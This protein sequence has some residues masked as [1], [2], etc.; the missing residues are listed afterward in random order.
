MTRLI[1]YKQVLDG[2][3]FRRGISG[4]PSDAQ[5]LEAAEYITTAY[6]HCLEYWPWPEASKSG[7]VTVTA[8]L[9][10]WATLLGADYYNFWTANPNLS[11]SGAVKLTPVSQ[12]DEGVRLDT[13]ATTVWARYW[14]RA[15]RFV[16]EELNGLAP[17]TYAFGK[18]GM[19]SD[20]HMYECVAVAGAMANVLSDPTKWRQLPILWLLSEPTKLLALAEWLGNSEQERAQAADLRSQAEIKLRELYDRT[21]K[22]FEP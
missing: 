16:G 3:A 11:N 13:T 17:I 10:T 1:P 19:A 20:G 7:N 2:V 12:D 5:A 6:R 14:P 21:P 9:V 4:M 22:D 18:I 15:P 8:G